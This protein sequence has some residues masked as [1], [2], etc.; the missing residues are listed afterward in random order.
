[1]YEHSNLL[2]INISFGLKNI[3]TIT[4]LLSIYT[5]LFGSYTANNQFVYKPFTLYTSKVILQIYE[6][7]FHHQLSSAVNTEHRLDVDRL[8]RI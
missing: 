3:P 6:A 1:M 8:L 4:I 7:S 5:N 2:I